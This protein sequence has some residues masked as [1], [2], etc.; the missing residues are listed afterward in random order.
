MLDPVQRRQFASVVTRIV[1]G[2]LVSDGF[3]NAK[4]ATVTMSAR[5]DIAWLFTIT[6]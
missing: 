1:R 2:I 5:R 4:E 6:M 3:K